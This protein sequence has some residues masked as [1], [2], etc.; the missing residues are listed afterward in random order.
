MTKILEAHHFPLWS[1]FI[2]SLAEQD[3]LWDNK[4]SWDNYN[5]ATK[6]PTESSN[7]WVGSTVQLSV[8]PIYLYYTCTYTIAFNHQHFV[9]VKAVLWPRRMYHYDLQLH[10]VCWIIQWI[11]KN[12]CLYLTAATIKAINYSLVRHPL[13]PDINTLGSYM[14][15]F[16]VLC[17]LPG[18]ITTV[19]AWKPCQPESCGPFSIYGSGSS[20]CV[21]SSPTD[22]DLAQP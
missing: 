2:S 13:S 6:S 14:P 17:N 1:T 5:L 9:I 3:S 4:Y 21:T 19:W 10:R 20:Q 15:S 11:T 7:M 8:I 22:W 18:P 12:K 16:Y